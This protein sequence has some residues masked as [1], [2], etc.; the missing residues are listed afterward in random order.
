MTSLLLSPTASAPPADPAA[1]AAG[2]IQVMDL[3][4]RDN[5]EHPARAGNIVALLPRDA[6]D[7]LV[8]A[9]LHG[10][11]ANFQRIIQLA[12]LERHPRR[13]LV[14][15]EVCHGGPKYPDGGCR[16][17]TML[18][19]VASLKLRFPGRVHFLLSNHELSELTDYP[20]TKSGNI[21]LVSFRMGLQTVYGD[22]AAD[23][24]TAYKRFLRSCPIGLFAGS[25]FLSHSAPE[26]VDRDGYEADVLIRPLSDGDLENEGSIGRLVWGR[27]YRP[28]NAE[29]F[30]DLVEAA[31]LVHGHTPSETGFS[32]PNS[33]Q[34]I[35]DCSARPA[36]VAFLPVGPKVDHDEVVRRIMLIC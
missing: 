10:H 9:D 16:S 19:A 33:R 3:A 36:S 25:V 21:L 2:V 31:V 23:V 30:A 15:Q 4:A 17:H 13:H 5:L 1:L 22:H 12:D 27:D 14:L 7:V 8:T 6:A 29:S 26:N 28:A 11:Y 32:V 18:E 20:I 34:V 35:L 24:L